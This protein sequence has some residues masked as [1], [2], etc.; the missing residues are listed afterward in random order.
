[1]PELVELNLRTNAILVSG[2]GWLAKA[3]WPKLKLLNLSKNR[4]GSVGCEELARAG[5][6]LEFAIL[7][8]CQI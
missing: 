1:M 4:F 6:D 7:K 5:W 3:N 2:C 8:D